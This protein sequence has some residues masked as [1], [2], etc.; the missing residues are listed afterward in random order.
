[1]IIIN[2]FTKW[3]LASWG[4]GECSQIQLFLVLISYYGW[5]LLGVTARS[6][7]CFGLWPRY[8]SPLCNISNRLCPASIDLITTLHSSTMRSPW[9]SERESLFF[10]IVPFIACC[11]YICMVNIV[12]YKAVK[13]TMA[14]DNWFAMYP[15][16]L[17]VCLVHL[18]LFLAFIAPIQ[19]TLLLGYQA[20]G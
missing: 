1:M 11:L 8:N 18:F 4:G 5:W 15:S 2:I 20:W 12:C 14:V 13:C 7:I 3:L 17:V 10:W 9:E 16:V 19:L 6:C